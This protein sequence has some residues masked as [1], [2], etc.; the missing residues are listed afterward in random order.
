MQL[1]SAAGIA[2]TFNAPLGAL[3]F[4]QEI[5]LLGKLQLANFS[6]LVV[7][8]TTAVIAS[9]GIFGNAP[10]FAVPPFVV[11]SYWECLSYALLGIV[12]GALAALYT[13]L[14][15]AV[16][17]QRLKI[18]DQ[19]GDVVKAVRPLRMPRHL[20]LLPWRQSGIALAE[21]P[22]DLGLQARDLLGDV[23]TTGV[24]QMP[25]LFDLAFQLGDRPFEFE[26]M[27]HRP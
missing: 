4:A 2:T 13:R 10:V 25:Q 7:A 18:A 20:N 3:M 23:G 9:R 14:F 24:R 15:H 19:A 11:E 17:G 5:V 8:T 27:T 12:L 6:L 16:A 26:E 1:A 22:V 21:S